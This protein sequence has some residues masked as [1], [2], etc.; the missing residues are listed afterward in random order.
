MATSLRINIS[1]DN[2]GLLGVKQTDASA[3]KVTELLQ[4]DLEV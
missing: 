1:P 3:S 4:E 2:S